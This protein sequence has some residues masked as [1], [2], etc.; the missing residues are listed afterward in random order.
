[1]TP[2]IGNSLENVK[3]FQDWGGWGTQLIFKGTVR[4]KQQQCKREK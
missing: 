2:V 3:L 4:K 1:M